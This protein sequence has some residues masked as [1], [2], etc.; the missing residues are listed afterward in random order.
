MP[1]R[2][3]S[4]DLHTGVDEAGR[5]ALAGPVVAASAVAW[6]SFALAGLTDSK[7]LTEKKR[8]A[9]FERLAIELLDFA[10]CAL[11]HHVVD[12][13][14]I[15]QA[16]LQAMKQSHASLKISTQEIIIDG[17]DAPIQGSRAQIKADRDVVVVSAASIIAKV[18]RDRIMR[19]YHEIYPC[20]QFHTHKGYPTSLHRA[21]LL[22]YGPSPIHRL[23]YKLTTDSTDVNSFPKL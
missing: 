9:L 20:Y 10:Y 21:L 3:S 7:L 18:I 1:I 8:E 14:N 6:K 13:I 2:Y 19:H 15:R 17:C 23:S 11:D 12:T 22:Q 4:N 16:T 5:G